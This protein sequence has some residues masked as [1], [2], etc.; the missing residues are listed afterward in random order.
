MGQ[1]DAHVIECITPDERDFA[2]VDMG[3]S[4][5]KDAR[6]LDRI[7]TIVGTDSALVSNIFLTHPDED[8]YNY[9]MNFNKFR[10][11]KIHFHLGG[12][13]ALWDEGTMSKK[14]AF[15]E[16]IKPLI[17]DDDDDDD[18]DEDINEK[19]FRGYSEYTNDIFFK[20]ENGKRV[21]N[22][23]SKEVTLCNKKMNMEVFVGGYTSR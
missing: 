18:D 1:G 21:R 11:D 16:I 23:I 9:L 15:N 12:N 3:T 10:K 14:V 17:D 22:R 4:S 2:I 19:N 5:I 13:L 20:N 7:K 6:T 8:H